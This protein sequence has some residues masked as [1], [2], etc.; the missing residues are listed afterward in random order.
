MKIEKKIITKGIIISGLMNAS[1][2]IFLD[3]LLTQ[4]LLNLIQK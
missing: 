4:Q 3:F 1:V 2:L